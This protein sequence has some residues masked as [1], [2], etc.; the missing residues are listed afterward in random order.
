[1]TPSGVKTP[2]KPTRQPP[3]PGHAA[4]PRLGL[5]RPR[6][7][8]NIRAATE[9]IARAS[10]PSHYSPPNVIA[11]TYSDLDVALPACKPMNSIW[12]RLDRELM[13]DV[14]ALAA[15]FVVMGASF[16]AIAVSEG[17]S[18]WLVI[19]KNRITEHDLTA[20]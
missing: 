13:R 19:A 7:V 3:S 4:Q 1:M 11:V 14:G 12:R 20:H 18:M 16:G 9:R 6:R 17:V 8:I 5:F 2:N 15:A 10:E